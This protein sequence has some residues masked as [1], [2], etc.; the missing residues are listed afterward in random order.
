MHL[1]IAIAA[2]LFACSSLA[3]VIWSGRQTRRTY[4]KVGELQ[5]QRNRHSD[6]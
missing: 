1:A 6:H 5:A 4:Q 3:Y 2:L